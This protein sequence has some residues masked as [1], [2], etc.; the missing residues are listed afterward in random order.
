[1][2]RCI[3]GLTS[4]LTDQGPYEFS[5]SGAGDDYIDLVNTYLFSWGVQ[6]PFLS[7]NIIRCVPLLG[8]PTSGLFSLGRSFSGLV[9]VIIVVRFRIVTM[10]WFHSR[11]NSFRFR[12][13]NGTHRMIFSDKNGT[14]TPQLMRMHEIRIGFI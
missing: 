4:A 14:C 8:L 12:P 9:H 7:E 13:S 10:R 11:E 1:M 6:V 5:V 3:K 2:S